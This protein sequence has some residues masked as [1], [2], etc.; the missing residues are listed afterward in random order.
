MKYRFTAIYFW[1]LNSRNFRFVY[2]K[3]GLI[4]EIYRL[5]YE[6]ALFC[7]TQQT[8]VHGLHHGD[9]QQVYIHV[10]L[11]EMQA[12]GDPYIHGFWV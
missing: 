6:K 5:L 12:H 3:F 9:L 11:R 4:C 7:E 1:G 8:G 10:F 2:E